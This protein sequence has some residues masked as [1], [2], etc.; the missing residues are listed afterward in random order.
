MRGIVFSS[1]Q[2]GDL[3]ALGHWM[4]ETLKDAWIYFHPVCDQATNRVGV[5]VPS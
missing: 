1:P 3:V 4:F 2:F 5:F